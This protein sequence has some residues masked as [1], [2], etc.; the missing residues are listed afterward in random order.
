MAE[1]SGEFLQN[2]SQRPQDKPTSLCW[3]SSWASGAPLRKRMGTRM[4]TGE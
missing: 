3:I 4:E 2:L 1:K